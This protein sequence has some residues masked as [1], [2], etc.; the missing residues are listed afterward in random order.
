VYRISL[1]NARALR[2]LDWQPRVSLEEGLDLT[3]GYFR[4]QVANEPA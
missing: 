2:D 4:E 1:D 3:V